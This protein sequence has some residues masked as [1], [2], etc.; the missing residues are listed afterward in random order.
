MLM[1]T[2]YITTQ[3]TSLQIGSK[4][5]HTPAALEAWIAQTADEDGYVYLV[6]FSATLECEHSSYSF[7]GPTRFAASEFTVAAHDATLDEI[8]FLL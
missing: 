3:P 8:N 5:S 4:I 6:S 7:E 2:A 1:G